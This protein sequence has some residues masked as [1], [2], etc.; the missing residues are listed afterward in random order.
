MILLF[1]P[2]F[3]VNEGVK[4]NEEN[5]KRFT[6]RI[7]RKLFEKIKEQA[8]VNKRAIGKEIEFLLE[9]IFTKENR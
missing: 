2:T 8:K 7:D 4:M 9:E 6:L 1:Y 3:D 5:V